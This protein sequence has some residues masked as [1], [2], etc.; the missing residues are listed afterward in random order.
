M[1]RS[2]KHLSQESLTH[3]LSLLFR[4][5]P[6]KRQQNKIDHSMHESVMSGYGMMYVQDPSLLQFQERLK[7]DHGRSNLETLF[8]VKSIPKDTQM[9]AILDEVD[10]EQFRPAFKNFTPRLQRGQAP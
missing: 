5:I 1:V 3:A 6:D 4:D 10:R 7:E 2:L 8:G 9:R